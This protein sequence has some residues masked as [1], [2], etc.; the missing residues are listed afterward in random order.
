MDVFDDCMNNKNL[1]IMESYFSDGIQS[2]CNTIYLPQNY[3]QSNQTIRKN[4]NMLILF[5]LGAR[6]LRE[7]YANVILG[8]MDKNRFYSYC[9][10]V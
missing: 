3:F 7:V 2:N 1:F 9:N 5:K 10:N 6:D 4:A 8:M